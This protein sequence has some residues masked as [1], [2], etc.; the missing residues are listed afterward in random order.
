MATSRDWAILNEMDSK[1]DYPEVIW[2]YADAMQDDS[3]LLMGRPMT[4][5]ESYEQS[6]GCGE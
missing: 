5:D 3:E 4:I 1:G 2:D 6:L